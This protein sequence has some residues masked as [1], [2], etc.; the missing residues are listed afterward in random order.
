MVGS[1]SGDGD[2]WV[3]LVVSV[4]PHHRLSGGEMIAKGSKIKNDRVEVGCGNR[5]VG[6]KSCT[7]CWEMVWFGWR[8]MRW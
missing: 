4:S 7:K 3:I 8:I 2:G 6:I 1:S 5:N